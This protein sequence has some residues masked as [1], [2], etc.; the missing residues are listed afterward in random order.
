MLK[1]LFFV[2][3]LAGI[4]SLAFV[5]PNDNFNGDNECKPDTARIA[6]VEFIVPGMDSATVTDVQNRL[7]ATCGVSFNFACW[8][9][10]VVFVEYDSL[11]TNKRIL[12]A[13]IEEMGYEPGVKH[14][15]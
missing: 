3:I 8:A 4:F 15:Y 11:L 1:P 2:V 14:H 6:V 12:M 5:S 10:T 9:D 13:V 7:D